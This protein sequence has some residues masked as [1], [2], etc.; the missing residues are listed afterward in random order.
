MALTS[1][2]AVLHPASC[3]KVPVQDSSITDHLP[4]KLSTP[5]KKEPQV[6]SLSA[7]KHGLGFGQLIL[8]GLLLSWNKNQQCSLFMRVPFLKCLKSQPTGTS[9]KQWLRCEI[10]CT[11]KHSSSEMG[12]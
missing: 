7:S 1:I 5:Q 12:M 4:K 11:V 10:R 3:K 9:S 2:W 8:S 6:S